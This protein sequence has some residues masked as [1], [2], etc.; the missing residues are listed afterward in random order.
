[1]KK[2]KVE[3]TIDGKK[4]TSY[5]NE[6]EYLKFKMGGTTEPKQRLKVNEKKKGSHCKYCDKKL[7]WHWIYNEDGKFC[8]FDC[9]L[10]WKEKK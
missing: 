8:G 4:Q 1:M 10:D 7:T 3:I 5:L 6:K 2:Y 9:Y